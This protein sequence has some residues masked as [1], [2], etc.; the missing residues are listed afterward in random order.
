MTFEDDCLPVQTLACSTQS[1]LEV[2]Q[3]C[4]SFM[5]VLNV[6][7]QLI[8]EVVI[9]QTHHVTTMTV[10]RTQHGRQSFLKI[11]HYQDQQFFF[12]SHIDLEKTVTEIS[13]DVNQQITAYES[14]KCRING[15][16]TKN[17]C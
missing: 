6:Q 17:N 12:S 3:S 9:E 13:D 14:G 2:A 16:F 4:G 8:E 5:Y 11:R 1:T 15:D 7:R 10:R